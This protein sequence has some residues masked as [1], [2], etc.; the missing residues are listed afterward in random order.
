MILEKL[1]DEKKFID[2]T[3]YTISNNSGVNMYNC[4]EKLVDVYDLLDP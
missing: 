3:T 2:G 1:P 4:K